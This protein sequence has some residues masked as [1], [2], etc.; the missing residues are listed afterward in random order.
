MYYKSTNHILF[1]N[2]FLFFQHHCRSCGTVVCGPCSSK[3]FLLPN[4]SSKPLRVC[5]NCFDK[6][7]RD[8]AQQNSNNLNY[9]KNCMFYYKNIKNIV[10]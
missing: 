7:S 2:L 10:I 4:Q 5:L 3:R 8:K 1:I 9:L 6:L